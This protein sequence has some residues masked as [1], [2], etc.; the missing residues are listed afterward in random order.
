[1]KEII[2]TCIL[3]VS[4]NTRSAI[5]ADLSVENIVLFTTWHYLTYGP[6]ITTTF[7]VWSHSIRVTCIIPSD[8]VYR[9]HVHHSTAWEEKNRLFF[10]SSCKWSVEGS[11]KLKCIRHS[12]CNASWNFPWHHRGFY[13]DRRRSWEKVMLKQT[14]NVK[15]TLFNL[16]SSSSTSNVVSVCHKLWQ[17]M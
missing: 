17:R 14:G 15:L 6:L 8:N 7:C 10:Y 4:Y 12:G 11:D 3:F 1:M 9:K 2:E 16:H 13:S 5:F